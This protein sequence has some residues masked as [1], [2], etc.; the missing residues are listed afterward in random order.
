MMTTG[1]KTA[2]NNAAKP[3]ML[4]KAATPEIAKAKKNAMAAENSFKTNYS[5]LRFF[6]SSEGGAKG[7]MPGPLYM[8]LGITLRIR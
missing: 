5:F 1:Q 6:T 4:K 7:E 3:V 2:A 8:M